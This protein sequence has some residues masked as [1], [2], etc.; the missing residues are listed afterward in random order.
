MCRDRR[1]GLSESAR[2]LLRCVTLV[3]LAL[4]VFTTA[5]LNISL[6]LIVTTLYTPVALSARRYRYERTAAGRRGCVKCYRLRVVYWGRVITNYCWHLLGVYGDWEAQ[7]ATASAWV[8][9]L[10]SCTYIIP[11]AHVQDLLL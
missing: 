10:Y 11:N 7:S 6:A 4:L 9:G 5:L 8:R 3:E 1:A 2:L